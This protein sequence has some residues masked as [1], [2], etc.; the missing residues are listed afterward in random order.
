M[1][2]HAR[3]LRGT[4]SRRPPAVPRM[5]PRCTRVRNAP[6]RAG[7]FA[8][9]ALQALAGCA[10]A[11]APDGASS[12]RGPAPGP[13]A[14]YEVF[15]AAESADLL[16]RVRFGPDGAE[17]AAT[18]PVGE[19]A[20]ETEG[21]HGV[22]TSQDGRW[23]YM[24]TGHGVPDGKLWKY[25]AGPDTLVGEPVLL[26]RFPATLDLTPDGL[27]AFVANFNLHGEHLPSTVS[28]VFTPDMTEVDRIETCVMPHGLRIAPDGDRLYTN[29]MMD[30]L[31][32][33]IDTRAFQ[34][35]RWFSVADGDE[36]PSPGPMHFARRGSNG[37]RGMQP[38]AGARRTP[39]TC[40]PTWV[41]PSVDGGSVFVAC[42]GAARILEIDREGWV[43]ARTL[44]TSRP[45]PYNLDASADGRFLV[46]TL[47]A[48]DAVEL[49]DL[50]TGE[51]LGVL[52][53]STT[54]PHGV[55][56]TP[57]SRYA[58]VSVEGVGAEPG[59]VDIFSLHPFR[60]VGSVE[61]GQQAGGIALWRMEPTKREE[62]P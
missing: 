35:S 44:R 9:L 55:V 36:G 38:G 27:Y 21:P 10:G 34:V 20:V 15:V 3:Q 43:L 59:K 18:V 4:P 26:G 48:S 29:C 1:N 17:L 6:P 33:E 61:V 40:S 45:G 50:R 62:R 14:V 58:F 54:I 30:D 41:E 23:L 11:P 2:D 49:F 8:C 47:K 32:V 19:T 22:N 12:E 5:R 46:A 53:T 13:D 37:D 28:V 7:I 25:D 42:N 52:P 24:T 60:G 57:D 16:H 56:I 31:T 39:P 51:S